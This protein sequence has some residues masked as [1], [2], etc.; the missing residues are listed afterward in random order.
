MMR[1]A[2]FGPPPRRFAVPSTAGRLALSIPL[3]VEGG[4]ISG[5]PFKPFRRAISARSSIIVAP[6]AP[7]RFKSSTTRTRN[8]A[9]DKAS[10]SGGRFIT[11]MN[12]NPTGKPTKI[13]T[14]RPGFCPYYSSPG[15][16]C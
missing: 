11:R 7:T 15:P 2:V 16:N 3:G 6:S 12:Q 9:V 8:S 10:I 5:R 14:R 1:V 4:L 13:S